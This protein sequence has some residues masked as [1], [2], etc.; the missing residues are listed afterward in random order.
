MNLCPCGSTTEYTLCCGRFIDASEASQ[1]PEQL[2]R[3]RY[4]AY[5]QANMDYI[6]Q[7]M[8]PPAANEFEPN[9][10]RKWAQQSEWL[11]LNIVKTAT[12]GDKG[13]VEFIALFNLQKEKHVLHELSE[14]HRV[15]GRWYYVDGETPESRKPVKVSHIGRNDPC[16][17]GSGKKYKKCCGH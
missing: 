7:T 17:C 15:D 5:T 10:S 11:G 16:S 14:F 13:W 1:T 6:L 12:E 4:T 8:K 9:S 2:M 3:S